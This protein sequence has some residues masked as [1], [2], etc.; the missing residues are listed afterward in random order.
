VAKLANN[1]MGAVITLGIAEGLALARRFGADV[2]R[3]CEA[4]TGGSGSSWILREWIPETVLAGDYR[5]RFSVDL[6]RKD[7]RLIAGECERLGIAAPAAALARATFD[8][9]A[10]AGHGEEDFS[11]VAALVEPAFGGNPSTAQTKGVASR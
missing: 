3:V 11:I 9:A 5:R 8:D 6:M 1:L 7:L 4:I 10:A 2:E